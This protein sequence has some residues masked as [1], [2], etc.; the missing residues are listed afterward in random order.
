MADTPPSR[1]REESELGFLEITVLFLSVYVLGAL[2]LQFFL[3][4][5]PEI[6]ALIDGIDFW[7]CMVF[8]LDFAVRFHR[9]ESKSRFMR[10]GW[11]DLIS[12]IPMVDPLRWG[13]LARVFRIIRVLR[14][15][16]STRRIVAFLYRRRFSGM[17]WTAALTVLLLMIFSSIAILALENEP[18][19][20]I[21]TPL[22]AVWWACSTITTVGYG[23]RFP[24]T[25]EGRV[26]AI[27][28]MIAGISLFG[29]LT[30]LFARLFVEPELRKEDSDIQL[31]TREVRLLRE[32][33]E[34]LENS[35][36]PTVDC[37]GTA[38]SSSSDRGSLPG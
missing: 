19:S 24:V 27:V 35:S 21:K 5:S 16:G 14:A 7:V 36:R 1:D 10:W 33:I 20:N 11:I 12:S 2:L 23:D 22:D 29:V 34:R 13:R 3:P 6:D 8:L 30:G 31:L 37:N 28:L 9:A 26:V 18:E 4:L 38:D 25:S 15:F 17:G 32:K